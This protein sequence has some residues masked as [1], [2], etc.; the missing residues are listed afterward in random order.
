MPVIPVQVDLIDEYEHAV[1]LAEYPHVIGIPEDQFWGIL[2][3]D[4]Y[5]D[6][7]CNPIWTYDMRQMV[8]YY[9]KEAQEEIEKVCGYPLAP[10]WIVDEQQYY[11]FP[12]L[13]KWNKL[14]EAGFRHVDTIQAG[15]AINF[16]TDPAV[17]GPIAT[18][19]T[20]ED[21]IAIFHPNSEIEIDPSSVTIAGGTVT[22]RVPRCRLVSA[23]HVKNS[24]GGWPYADVPPSATSPYES[25]VDVARV[26]NDPSIQGG[27]VW[28]HRESNGECGCTCP[29]CGALCGDYRVNACMYIRNPETGAVD[30]TE[31]SYTNGAWTGVCANCYCENPTT[32]RL[33]YRAGLTPMTKQARDA[34]IRL[35]HVKM[36]HA[37][38]G[39]GIAQDA[40]SRDR[41]IPETLTTERLACPFGTEEGAF[42]SWKFAQAIRVQRGTFVG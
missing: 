16:A 19:V 21:E 28:P 5:G 37:P 24:S 31:A 9:L 4:T 34:V 36:P 40:W 11:G 7:A 25:T 30:L 41:K 6:E 13:A 8:A 26:Y 33:N 23:L 38:C 18:T 39:C 10:R 32:V 27:L 22:I 3:P 35:S 2:N 14:I 17:I 1:R 12:L 42:I 29:S 20:D 15:A